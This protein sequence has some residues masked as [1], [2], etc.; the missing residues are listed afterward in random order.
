[1]TDPAP[2]AAGFS[3]WAMP[4]GFD[5]MDLAT[6]M[7]ALQQQQPAAAEEEPVQEVPAV[8]APVPGLSPR[9]KPAI[10]A[11]APTPRDDEPPPLLVLVEALLFLG[12][13]PLGEARLLELL[14]GSQ[15]TEMSQCIH[16]INERYQAHKRPYRI[17]RQGS[18]WQARLNPS[19]R[20]LAERLRGN[21]P[22]L[23]LEGALLETL[24]IV[25][26]RQPV[27]RGEIDAMR[28]SDCT[29]MLRQL[30]KLGIIRGEGARDTAYRTT[31]AF[32]QLFGI[33]RL[34]DL[35]RPVDLE[36]Q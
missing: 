3:A 26:Y 14:P 18:G 25:A 32:L 17:V 30:T 29:P 22:T 36:K 35:P 10:P 4:D 7:E 20:G 13:P 27:K 11:A 9:K 31:P 34:E 21:V 1:M 24:A 12:G 2:D 33:D 19:H 6:A 5:G 28:G 8:P 16:R 15:A 23:R